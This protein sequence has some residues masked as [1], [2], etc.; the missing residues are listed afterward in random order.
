MSVVAE[1]PRA[2][3]HGVEQTSAAWWQTPMVLVVATA[4][5]QLQCLPV[6]CFPVSEAKPHGE[7]QE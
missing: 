6:L 4:S 5:R 7:I 2:D 3:V 1:D